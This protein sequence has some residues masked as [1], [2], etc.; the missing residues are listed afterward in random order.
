MTKNQN[1]LINRFNKSPFTSKEGLCS[2]LKDF[3]WYYEEGK[4]ETYFP[5]CYNVFNPEELTEF[6]DN[7][8]TTACISLL[9]WVTEQHEDK[10]SF[11]L[12]SDDGRVP[13]SCIQ[14]AINRCKDFIDCCLH[15]DIDSETDIKIWEHDWDVFLTQHYLLTHENGKFTMQEDGYACL[16]AYYDQAKR[17]LDKVKLLWPQFTLDG[18]LNIWIIKPGNKCR[19]RGII[20]MNNIKQIINTVNPP[21][22]ATK[23]RYVVQKYI[24][25]LKA[26]TLNFFVCVL[27]LLLFSFI[28]RPLIIHKTKFDIRQW[29]L[30]TSVQPLIVWFYKESYLRFSSQ[31]F[32]LQNYHES[33]HLTNHAIQ[34]KYTNGVRDERLPSVWQ[35]FINCFLND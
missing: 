28:E 7:F 13:M 5:R 10:G 33:V 35:L 12:T 30:V 26:M 8:R 4:S 9:R 20:L 32:N 11:F 19:G 31:Q 17:I 24:G 29:F 25:E 15:N 1:I 6:V 16:D 27:L 21:M 34:K 2:A 23:S 22:S 3:H 18:T 14:F